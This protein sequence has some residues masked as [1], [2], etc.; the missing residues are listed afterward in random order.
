MLPEN[1]YT[2]NFGNKKVIV[3]NNDVVVL[4]YPINSIIRQDTM[5][6]HHPEQLLT[7]RNDSLMLVLQ[8]ICIEDTIVTDVR[9]YD[10]Q[11][12]KKQTNNI[13]LITD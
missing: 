7:Y 8:S 4:E 10:F 5:L 12:F 9:S 13:C 2:C 6:L 11:L 3:K 1:K